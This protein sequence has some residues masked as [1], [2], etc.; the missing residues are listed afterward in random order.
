MGILLVY[1]VA[2]ESPFN[3]IRNWIRNIKQHASNNV[4]KIL[5]SNKDDMDESKRV[6]PTSRGQALTDEYGIKFFETVSS[7][8]CEI[9]R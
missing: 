6:V 5:V 8:C 7:D 9:K 1:D 3:N 4:N 2:D